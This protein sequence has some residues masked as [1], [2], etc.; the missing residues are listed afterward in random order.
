MQIETILRQCSIY[1]ICL[2]LIIRD[3]V[4]GYGF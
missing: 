2:L 4:V 3:N 1:R